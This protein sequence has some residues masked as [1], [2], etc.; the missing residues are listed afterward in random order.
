MLLIYDYMF[1]FIS[2]GFKYYVNKYDPLILCKKV[3]ISMKTMNYEI[4][5]LIIIFKCL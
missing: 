1:F 4:K 2:K 3:L 5:I